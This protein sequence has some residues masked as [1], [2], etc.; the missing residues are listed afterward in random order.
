[1][2]RND[3]A[4]RARGRAVEDNSNLRVESGEWRR[5]NGA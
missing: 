3:G 5:E 2:Q 4:L 1:M